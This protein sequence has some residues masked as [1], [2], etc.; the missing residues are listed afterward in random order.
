MNFFEHHLGIHSPASNLTWS[1]MSLR[2]IIVF[3]FGILCM[4]LADRRF[5]G[6]SAGFDV[7]LAIILGSVLSRGINGQ[8]PFFP[9]LGAS[10]LLIVIHRLLGFV[11]CRFSGFSRL[12]KGDAITLVHGG[13]MIHE[14]MRRADISLD[15]LEENLRQNGNVASAQKVF[16]ARLERNGQ[17]SVV[18]N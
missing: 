16:E 14:A 18:K 12:I 4:R 15:D 8:A 9:T 10:G 7:F 3:L 17:I 6:K 2:T 11:A 13:Q 5:I 1:Q